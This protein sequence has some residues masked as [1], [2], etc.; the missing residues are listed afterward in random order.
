M[1]SVAIGCRFAAQAAFTT[2]V[3]RERRS[4]RVLDGRGSSMRCMDIVAVALALLAFL[5]LYGLI[6]LVDRI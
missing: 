4:A 5:A 1:A 6:A 3:C 2:S